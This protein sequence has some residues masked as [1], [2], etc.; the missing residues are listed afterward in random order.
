[1]GELKWFLRCHG[2][3]LNRQPVNRQ[4]GSRA[5]PSH[6]WTSRLLTSSFSLGFSSVFGRATQC[7]RDM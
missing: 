1:M 6:S 4:F 5:R 2:K 3:L 7:I